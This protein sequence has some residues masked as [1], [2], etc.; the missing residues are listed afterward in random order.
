M[1]QV[2]NAAVAR[3]NKFQEAR[4]RFLHSIFEFRPP[5]NRRAPEGAQE[6]PRGT[7]RASP[8][9]HFQIQLVRLRSPSGSVGWHGMGIAFTLRGELLAKLK[10]HEPNNPSTS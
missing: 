2:R 3:A 5:K 4:T 6:T 8:G 1:V 10:S 9:V 7:D